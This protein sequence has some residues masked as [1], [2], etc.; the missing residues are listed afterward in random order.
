MNVPNGVDTMKVTF[1]LLDLNYEAKAERPEIRIWGIS[2]SGERILIIDR[3]MPSYFYAIA[4]EETEPVKLVEE[5]KEG[6][7]PS[8]TKLEAVERKFFGRPVKAV[9]VYCNDPN[10]ISEYAKEIRK[11]EGAKDCLEDDIRHAMRYL[12]DNNI[13]PCGWHEVEATETDRI[14]DIKTEKSYLAKTTP[15][16]V[17]KTDAPKL[18]IL[19]F[20]T[21]YYS[22]EGTPKPE[23]NPVVIISTATNCGDQKQFMADEDRKD[24]H[25]LEEFMSHIQ[26]FDPDIIVGYGV[27]GQHWSYLT[28]RC[29]KSGLHLYVDRARAEPH[30]SVYSHVS[31]TG[32]ANLDLSDYIEE[33]QEIK[34]K[35]LENFADF[36]GV[37]KIEDRTTIEDIDIA[38]YWD[39]KTKRETLRKYSMD[40]TRC[41][42]GITDAVLDFASQLSN[43]VGLPL[44]HVGTAAAGFRVEWFLIKQTHKLGELVPKRIEQPYR[45][46]AGGLVLQPTPGL[47]DNIAALDFKSMYP[48]LMIT[49]NLSPDT[50]ISPKDPTPAGGVYEAPEVGH[51]F[52]KEPPGFYKE[53]LTYLI[54]VRGEIRARMKKL[55]PTSL[56]YRV[57]DSRQ[58][59]VKV[60]TNASYGY[61]GWTGARWYVKPVAEAAAAYGRHTIQTAIQMA[62]KAGLKVVY[63][64]TDS[65]F[66]QNDAQES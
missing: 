20:S 25:I 36:L 35:T 65:I 15:K 14:S 7:F 39:D 63:G 6:D 66:L 2:A 52:R 18:R 41:I 57:L 17:E 49:Y 10:A 38:D 16:L 50:Y 51:K 61:A 3:N 62:E 26:E 27:N 45:P 37:M 28:E 9:K 64:D 22:H 13:V 44:D 1:W 58:K 42:M 30:T 31:L 48:N 29:K 33:F 59:A 5:I 55:A 40:N 56:E 19:G 46:Y 43:L 4:K 23:R 32:R 12:I 11:L 8:I 53:V 60:I 24:K 34:V 21:I 54:K 47:H